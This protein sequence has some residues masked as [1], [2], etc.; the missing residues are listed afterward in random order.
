MA[1]PFVPV[2]IPMEQGRSW[3][4]RA[5]SLGS[6]SS[7]SGPLGDEAIPKMRGGNARG[8]E[9]AFPT[10]SLECHSPVT[11]A[12]LNGTSPSVEYSTSPRFHDDSSG[13]SWQERPITPTLLGYEVMEERAKFTVYKILVKKSQEES[14]V[15]FR[16]Y[17]DFSRLNDKLKDLFPGFR[18]SLP[19]K[20]WF[21]DNYDTEFLEERQL[22]L[23][24]FLQNLVTH[25]DTANSLAVREFLCLDDPPGPFDSLEE[26]R[27]FCETLEETNY[28][29]QKE[30]LEKQREIEELRKTLEEK[31]LHIHVLEKRINGDLLS[32]E[33]LESPC[34]LSGVGSE[35]SVDTDID[36]QSSAIE[37]DQE[38]D[39]D[40]C[41]GI[42]AH[43]KGHAACWCGPVTGSPP[44]VIQVTQ[45]PEAQPLH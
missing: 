5:A 23:Q 45:E 4:R 24:V 3:V 38:M 40:N 43:R 15:V 18:F 16:R 44:P 9:G 32:P 19:P 30:L 7:S 27:A 17:T 37:A 22:G 20:R 2:P 12:R 34:R 42:Q 13:S 33:S 10:P 26:S 8:P 28:R 21:K 36:V 39:Q 1:M 29:L 41:S 14:W 6:V 35:S 11:R 31:Q 25:K